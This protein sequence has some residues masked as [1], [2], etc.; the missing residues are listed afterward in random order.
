LDIPNI[1]LSFPDASGRDL[2]WDTCEGT[3]VVT[4]HKQGLEKALAAL[5][6][7]MAEEIRAFVKRLD[8]KGKPGSMLAFDSA[9]GRKV[10]VAA[11][12]RGKMF[13]QLEW[14]RKVLSAFRATNVRFLLID[15]RTLSDEETD[16]LAHVLASAAAV[17]HFKLPNYRSKKGDD[18]KEAK[19]VHLTFAISAGKVATAR[20][21]AEQ[22]IILAAG[23]NLVRKLAHMAGNDLTTSRYVEVATE[24]A[25]GGGL[26]VDFLSLKRLTQMGAG[27]FLAVAQ[28]SDDKGAGILKVI[29][30]PAG[31]ITK[32]LAL[33]GK[34]ITFDTGGS[35]L[36]TGSY[37]FGM[38]QDMTGSA[39]ALATALVAAKLKWP[40]QVT[41][42]LAI[43]DNILGPR[44]YRPNDIVKSL[45]GTTIEVID[46]DAEGRM[47]LADTL[48]LASSEK[49]D[50]VID[51]ATLTGSCIR[52]LGTRYS[53]GYMNRKSLFPKVRKAG[54]SSGERVWPMPNDLDYGRSIKSKIA[55]IAQCR[56]SG[57]VDHIEASY[58]LR[59]FVAKGVPWVHIDLA[60]ANHD[61]G[62]AHV[63]GKTTG[64]GVRFASELVRLVLS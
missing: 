58:F 44:S 21:T 47:V 18:A 27:A 45:K 35:N 43:T 4:G 1:K 29:Y 8:Y 61:G 49:P 46:T 25:K 40:Y 39:V 37:M 32:K 22:A 42:Y 6:R 19:P 38:H 13:S 54:V 26:K 15:G 5:P 9:T 10:V 57:G 52:A 59:Q 33:V 63:P 34:G 24:L 23:T 56:V 60:A 62:L 31:K 20:A 2:P 28:G 53:G 7:P 14:A 30:Q 36:K 16:T 41:A 48:W 17:S 12:P 50:L 3:L 51:F 55:D 64:F 11:V